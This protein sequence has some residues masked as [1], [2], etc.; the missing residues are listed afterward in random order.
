MNKSETK[1]YSIMTMRSLHKWWENITKIWAL[2]EI[3]SP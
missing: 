3:Y 2:L 1:A